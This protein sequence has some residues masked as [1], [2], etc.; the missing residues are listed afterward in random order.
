MFLQ[1]DQFTPDAGIET[2][3][4][5]IDIV[6]DADRGDSGAFLVVD[7][8]HDVQGVA[9]PRV[10]IRDNRNADRFG[11]VPFDFELLAG[12]DKACVGNAFQRCGNRKTAGPNGVESSSLDQFGTEGIMGADGLDNAWSSEQLS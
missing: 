8:A 4:F 9:V 2:T 3:A 1:R 11:D 10:A 5:W 7:G 12:R 6:L